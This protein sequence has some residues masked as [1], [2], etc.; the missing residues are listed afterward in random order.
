MAGSRQPTVRFDEDKR[1]D[2]DQAQSQDLATS[3]IANPYSQD[4][5]LPQLRSR[6][7]PA[8]RPNLSASRGQDGL[9][10]G[11]GSRSPSGGRGVE[12]LIPTPDTAAAGP[13][14]APGAYLTDTSLSV[15]KIISLERDLAT[16]R[17]RVRRTAAAFDVDTL[18]PPCAPGQGKG[19]KG[20]ESRSRRERARSGLEAQIGRTFRLAHQQTQDVLAMVEGWEAPIVH[21]RTAREGRASLRQPGYGSGAGTTSSTATSASRFLAA[22]NAALERCEALLLRDGAWDG[23]EARAQLSLYAALRPFPLALAH[24]APHAGPDDATSWPALD[25]ALLHPWAARSRSLGR[26]LSRAYRSLLLRCLVAVSALLCAL[27]LA[28]PRLVRLAS[29]LPGPPR[30]LPAVPP[31][32]LMFA[33][34]GA[35]LLLALA[36]WDCSLSRGAA[37]A[38]DERLAGVWTKKLAQDSL[39][40]PWISGEEGAWKAYLASSRCL[41]IGA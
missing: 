12:R 40:G 39:W 31:S 41:G 18:G 4:P 15:A 23:A 21:V 2:G 20:A 27:F 37:V 36:L 24:L 10:A 35:I 33:V 38:R 34:A 32:S 19:G 6:A 30:S 7:S 5:T 29:M 22:A 17:R 13:R 3:D 28:W 11:S 1:P 25:F 14:A 16:L 9:M 8:P 26:V